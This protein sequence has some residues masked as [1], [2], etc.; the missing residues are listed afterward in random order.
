MWR[1]GSRDA[2]MVACSSPEIDSHANYQNHPVPLR[3]AA[4]LCARAPADR[5]GER[6]RPRRCRAGCARRGLCAGQPLPE[7]R[8]L[9]A[10]GRRVGRLDGRPGSPS[11]RA[12]AGSRSV[13][14]QDDVVCDACGDQ[15]SVL[16]V[17][18]RVAVVC[19]DDDAHEIHLLS[20]Q[21]ASHLFMRRR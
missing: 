3:R 15:H 10:D 5:M 17:A 19:D 7:G 20:G 1:W 2:R 9:P 21:V 18:E 6:D 8:A 4:A 14:E 12:G 13:L 11:L 16:V